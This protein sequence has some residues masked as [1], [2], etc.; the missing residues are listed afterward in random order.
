VRSPIAA[1]IPASR[2]VPISVNKGTP[3]TL[4]HPGHPVSKA[5]TRFARQHLMPAPARR[6]GLLGRSRRR[7]A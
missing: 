6:G 4:A 5:I 2:A 7:A 3:I 1:E